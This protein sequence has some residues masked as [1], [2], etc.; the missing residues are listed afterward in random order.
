[1]L[2]GW[3]ENRFEPENADANIAAANPAGLAAEDLQQKISSRR[4]LLEM[5]QLFSCCTS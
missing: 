3:L 2:E 1:M 4:Y 5:L